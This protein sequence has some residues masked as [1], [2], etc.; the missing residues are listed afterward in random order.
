MEGSNNEM[1][2][3]K[4]AKQIREESSGIKNMIALV[5]IEMIQIIEDP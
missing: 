3:R 4:K 1:F 5:W 2:Y